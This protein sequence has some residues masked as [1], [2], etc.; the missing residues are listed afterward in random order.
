MYCDILFSTAVPPLTIIM[1]RPW[2]YY[3]RTWGAYGP[4]EA[5]CFFFF[6]FFFFFFCLL[7]IFVFL[8]CCLFVFLPFCLFVFLPF[9]LFAFLPFCLFAFLPFYL[10]VFMSFC[11]FVT[12]IIITGSI[13]T[14]TQIFVPI[15]QFFNFTTHFTTYFTT[16]FTTNHY[17]YCHPL[18]HNVLCT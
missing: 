12:T 1:H 15:Q 3:T 14:T 18:P 11:L 17:H 10:F 8:P 6:F 9:C 13:Y 5:P 16:N 4:L 2:V 7:V